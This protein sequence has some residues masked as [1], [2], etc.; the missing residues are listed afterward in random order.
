MSPDRLTRRTLMATLATA[1]TAVALS[2]ASAADSA[3]DD[4]SWKIT[5]GRINQS[6]V[7]WCFKPMTTEELARHAAALGLKSLELA[8]PDYR[9]VA[10]DTYTKV[11]ETGT[12]A[13]FEIMY[14]G[15]TAL[16]WDVRV[17]PIRVGEAIIGLIVITSDVTEQRALV[18]GD[19]TRRRVG[20]DRAPDREQ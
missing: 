6:V 14:W 3:A 2:H 13:R 12:S 15:Q 8:P 17:G 9:Q 5:K 19:V 1:G 4:P 11:L 20:L 10:S 7:Q 18:D 16:V